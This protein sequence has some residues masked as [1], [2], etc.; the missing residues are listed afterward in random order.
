M[1]LCNLEMRLCDEGGSCD[2]HFGGAC[3]SDV[4]QV[5]DCDARYCSPLQARCADCLAD[6]DCAVEGAGMFCN[7]GDCRACEP[8]KIGLTQENG[9]AWEFYE[10]CA[11]GASAASLQAALRTIRQVTRQL[12]P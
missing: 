9:G 12:I 2:E 6:C 4:C 3:Q 5:V 7:D 1:G 11:T 10:L 8:G